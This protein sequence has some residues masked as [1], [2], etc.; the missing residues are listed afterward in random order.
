[1]PPPTSLPGLD[2]L[3]AICQQHALACELCPPLA[4]ASELKE[5]IS[6]EPLDPQL[7]AVYQRIGGA[8]LGPLS[9]YRPDLEWDGLVPENMDLRRHGLMPFLASLIFA[10]EIGFSYYLA[11]VPRLADSQ[12]LQPVVYI[13]FMEPPTTVPVASSVD[14]FFDTYSRYLELMVVDPEYIYS[15]NPEII[16]PRGVPQLI[17]RDEPLMELVRAGRFDFLT[18]DDEEGHQWT[19][20]LPSSRQE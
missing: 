17:A 14:R 8:K 13:D 4:S 10:K 18:G 16:F 11:T 20:R 9:I 6:G 5:F 15:R 12:G 7:A 19:Q 3:I 2:R 1:M